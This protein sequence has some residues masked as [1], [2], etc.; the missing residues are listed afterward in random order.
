M[1]EFMKKKIFKKNRLVILA[2]SVMIG[3]AGYLNFNAGKK[4]DQLRHSDTTG[5]TA[6]IEVVSYNNDI[7][8]EDDQEDSLEDSSYIEQAALEE[9]VE[10][11]GDEEDIGEAVLTNAE[12]ASSDAA[13]TNAEAVKNNMA[14]AKLN[15]EQ[16]RSRSKEALLDIINDETLDDATKENAISSYVALADNIEKETD[17]ETLLTAKGYTD[18]IV[19]ISDNAVDVA[20]MTDELSDT[21]RACIED[22]VTRKTGYDISQVVISL[23]YNK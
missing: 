18:C 1:E 17:T 3:V 23:A 20:L 10:L 12:V 6:D 16:S 19:T 14:T 22:I 21:E 5:N 11:N 13:L 2:L 15:R 7:S 8:S 4:E 9:N